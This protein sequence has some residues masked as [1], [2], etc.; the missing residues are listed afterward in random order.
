VREL[1]CP[2]VRFLS[3]GDESAFF[4]WAE[5]VPGIASVTGE[6]ENIVLMAR[7]RLSEHALRELLALFHRYNVPLGQ[8]AVF[9]TPANARWFTSPN[10]YWYK[11]VFP[12][13]A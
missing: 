3:P 13:G 12:N 7:A 2:R 1:R 8:L 11:S 10:A 9:A 6:G 4:R 5:G